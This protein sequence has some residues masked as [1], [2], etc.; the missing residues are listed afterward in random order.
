M[1]VLLA[2]YIESWGRGID[3]MM[4]ACKEYDL[5]EPVVTEEQG[6]ISVTFLKDVYTLDYLKSFHLSDRQTKAV[7]YIKENE[8]I[9]N[10]SISDR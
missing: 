3:I 1:C 10:G 6:G 7:L 8:E 5:P 2:G 9:T 4:N